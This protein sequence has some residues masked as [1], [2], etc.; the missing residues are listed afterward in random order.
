VIGGPKAVRSE[1]ATVQLRIWLR[2]AWKLTRSCALC[3]SLNRSRHS[4]HPAWT[5]QA[6]LEPIGLVD[7][8][9]MK[10]AACGIL[11]PREV[12]QTL[13]RADSGSRV[14]W[15][16][17]RWRLR[18]VIAPTEQLRINF[19]VGPKSDASW[20]SRR[21]RTAFGAPIISAYQS[22]IKM[23]TDYRLHLGISR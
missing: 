23:I 12:F 2:A 3:A 10:A 16:D 5:A 14:W 20:D 8:C 18:F 21:Y 9:S 7:E 22:P 6:A 17:K 15:H 4:R 13:V 11:R 1:A 19:E